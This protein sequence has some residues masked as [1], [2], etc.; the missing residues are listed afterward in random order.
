[1]GLRGLFGDWGFRGCVGGDEDMDLGIIEMRSHVFLVQG[2]GIVALV[3]SRA[4]IVSAFF[5]LMMV[6]SGNGNKQL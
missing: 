3:G 4:C 1:M 6:S 2:C 5:V